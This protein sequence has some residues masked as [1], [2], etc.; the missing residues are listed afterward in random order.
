MS[1]ITPEGSV[2]RGCAFCGAD[3]DAGAPPEHVI[4][5][6]VSHAYPT[7]I[8]SRIDKDGNEHRGKIIDMTVETVCADCNHHWMSDLETRSAPVLK[9]ML[10]GERRGLSV[11]Q[12][13]TL[14]TWA[15]KTAMVVEQEYPPSERVWPTPLYK[16]LM[17]RKLPPPEVGVQLA[18]YE[19]TG[20]FLQVGHVDL[21]KRTIPEGARPRPP[22][23]HRTAIRID[24]LIVEVHRTEKPIDIRIG[25]SN[26]P[27]ITLRDLILPIWPS[28]KAA[29]WPPR[30]SFNDSVWHSFMEPELPDAAQQ[31]E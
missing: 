2:V 1:G 29:A 17:D 8:F 27:G 10:R 9:P 15:T 19:G 13:A 23:G 16:E 14:A 21:Y 3:I 4:P 18:R 20:D 26:A 22:D 6:W 12:Q 31:G 5:K 28:A 11:S 30:F 25:A 24:H 7:A